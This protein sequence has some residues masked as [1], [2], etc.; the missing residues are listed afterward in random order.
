MNISTIRVQA[1]ATVTASPDQAV[2][3]ISVVTQAAKADDAAGQNAEKADRI[4]QRLRKVLNTQTGISTVNYSLTPDYRYPK[5][6]GQP[7]IVGYTASNTVEVR[8]GELPKVGDLIDAAISSGANNIQALRFELKDDA[9]VAAR[10]L[11]EAAKK[12]REKADAIAAAL[13][14]NIVRVVS[15][16]EGGPV[17]I[18]VRERTFAMAKA[19]ASAAPTPVEAGNIEVQATV[20]LTVEIR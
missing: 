9:A 18:P 5:E 2:I 10:A 6:G 1:D 12:A 15:V 20:T 19:E 7:K 4:M 8:T 3:Q 11:A 16:E 13:Q 17:V 14:L